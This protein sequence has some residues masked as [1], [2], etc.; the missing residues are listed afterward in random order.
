M[1]EPGSTGGAG[2]P[3]Q[4][5]GGPWFAPGLVDE[6][7]ET[8]SSMIFESWVG[9]LI[10]RETPEHPAIIMITMR[11]SKVVRDKADTP[12]VHYMPLFYAS[13][14]VSSTNGSVFP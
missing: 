3:C 6:L 2:G 1:G 5:G 11:P 9:A 7:S 10:S 13:G 8:S 12:A 4:A 14:L